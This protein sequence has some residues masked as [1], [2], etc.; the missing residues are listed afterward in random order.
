MS[1]SESGSAEPTDRPSGLWSLGV[2]YLKGLA[3]GAADAVPG[4][5][6][7]TIALITGVYERLIRALTNLDPTV[8]FGIGSLHR[9]EGRERFKRSLVEMD[10]PFLVSLG[11]GMV[12]A[13]VILAQLVQIALS[14]VPGPTFA[15]FFGLIGASAIVLF[16]RKWIYRPGS[17]FA[18][19]LGFVLAFLVAGETATGSVPHTLPVIFGAGV[20]AI[21]GMILPGISGA[22][23]LL[24]LGQYDYMTATLDRFI[25]ASIGLLTGGDLAEFLDAVSVI[26]VFIAGAVVG[27]FTVAFAIRAALERY[28]SAT[29]A[30]L[31]SLMI[32]ALRYPLIRIVDV[33]GTWTLPTAGGIIGAGVVGLLAVLV[34]DTYTEDLD[35]D[36]GASRTAEKL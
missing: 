4:V 6:G 1:S 34:L 11:L 21:S 22:F 32:G 2:V 35:Y 19:V 36:G 23:I 31:V 10:V 18:A 29:F 30:F 16:D 14:A 33:T 26:V 20:V 24:L 8:V 17:I 25:D 28:R 5:S 12:T 27:L 7:G 3:M 15:F 13:V 9:P